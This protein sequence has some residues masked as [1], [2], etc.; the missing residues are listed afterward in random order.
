M[1]IGKPQCSRIIRNPIL[2]SELISLFIIDK[3]WGQ[4]KYVRKFEI[5]REILEKTQKLS[6]RKFFLLI[7]YNKHEKIY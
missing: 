4:H 2:F 3:S 1:Y 5:S 7:L 6:I